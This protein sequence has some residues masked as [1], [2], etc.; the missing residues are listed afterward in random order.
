MTFKIDT[1]HITL[2]ANNVEALT[3]S[4]LT[5]NRSINALHK[6]IEQL[7]QQSN[8]TNQNQANQQK[9]QAPVTTSVTQSQYDSR[10][11][12]EELFLQMPKPIVH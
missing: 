3:E 5:L 4:L 1:K 8:H 10:A 2:D 9:R 6:A 11:E 12:Q 7:N